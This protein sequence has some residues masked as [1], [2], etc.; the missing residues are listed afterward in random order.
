[1]KKI[2]LALMSIALMAGSAFAQQKLQEVVYLKNGSIVRGVITEQVPEKSLKIQ[3]ADGSVFSYTMSEVEKITKEPVANVIKRIDGIAKNYEKSYQ[4]LSFTYNPVKLKYDD[5]DYDDSFSMN[6]LSINW[7]M[8]RQIVN[9]APLY[10]EFGLGALYA[11]GNDEGYE[12][13]LISVNLPFA[14][15]WRFDIDDKIKIAPYWGIN[16]RGNIIGKSKYDD[17]EYSSEYDWFSG[18]EAEGKRINVGM[19]L[20][21]N[22]NYDRFMFG[23]GYTFDFNKIDIEYKPLNYVGI[24]V[25]LNF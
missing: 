18:E 2:L 25:G 8:G 21:V 15:T 19:T 23:V 9:D 7:T 13:T 1:M 10:F 22:F 11:F 17:D 24:S 3:T 16:L 20:G 4:R 14:L 5:D 12:E 6:A